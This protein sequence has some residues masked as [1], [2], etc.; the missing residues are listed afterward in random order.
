MVIRYNGIEVSRENRTVSH[1]GETHQFARKVDHKLFELFCYVLL[2]GGVSKEQSFY[3][4]YA[5]D[6]DGGPLAGPHIFHILINKLE[7][8]FFA[9]LQIE[10]RAWRISG[11]NFYS[12]V[13]KHQVHDS[14]RRELYVNSRRRAYKESRNVQP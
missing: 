4:L 7:L 1:L 9:R 14:K 8:M 2:S 12:I 6:P 3:H 11:V 10:W 5:N 13:P